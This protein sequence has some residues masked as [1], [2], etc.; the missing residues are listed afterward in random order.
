M[1]PPYSLDSAGVERICWA[2]LRRTEKYCARPGLIARRETLRRMD[3]IAVHDHLGTDRRH[4]A[5]FFR[6]VH[7]DSY[8]AVA[9]WARRHRRVSMNCYAAHDVIRVIQQSKR[10]FSPT[11]ELAIDSEMTRRRDGRLSIVIQRKR[12]SV[13]G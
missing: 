6:G 11:G 8:T 3:R 2:L 5:E 4:L 7:G 13:A 9:R 12:F 1:C 10:A